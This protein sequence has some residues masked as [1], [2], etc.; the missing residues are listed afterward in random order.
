MDGKTYGLPDMDWHQTVA[1][2]YLLY[3]IKDKHPRAGRMFNA[4]V[5]DLDTLLQEYL[6]IACG[7][8]SRHVTRL[9]V[10]YPTRKA[11]GVMVPERTPTD[12]T[13]A[14]T[15]YRLLSKSIAA[16]DLLFSLRALFNI[17]RFWQTGLGGQRWA[18]IAEV[19]LLRVRGELSPIAFV[20]QCF[21]LVHNG[22]I[23][24]NKGWNFSPAL[25]S[26]ML[27]LAMRGDLKALAPFAREGVRSL[28]EQVVVSPGA[29]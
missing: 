1:D 14:W 7:G 5:Q 13:V 22:T 21:S 12:R 28:W 18:K 25:L 2:F 8:E 26:V 4:L 19:G 24:L 23:F 6:L 11:N 20:D 27:T 15:Y 9:D 17:R 3:D 29:P 10:M 16:E